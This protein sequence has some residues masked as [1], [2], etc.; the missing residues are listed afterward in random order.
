[1]RPRSA[2]FL[3]L[4]LLSLILVAAV[5]VARAQALDFRRTNFA[6]G[7]GPGSLV[8]ADLN[9]DGKLDLVSSDGGYP[10]TVSVLL[11]TGNGGFAARTAFAPARQPG[12][13]A[14]GDV[15]EDGHVDV[16][17]ATST[18]EDV[19]GPLVG[20][21]S[22]LYGDGAGR[23]S[24][25][26]AAFPTGIGACAVAVADLDKDGHLDIVT[27]NGAEGWD[28]GDAPGNS[29]SVLL[30]DGSGGFAAH[31]DFATGAYPKEVKVADLDK[32]GNL[33]LVT[34]N[35]G[36]WEAY[37]NTVSVLRG[38]GSGGFAAKTSFTTGALPTAVAV[39][40]LD[41]D[42]DLDLVSANEGDTTV[43]VLLGN[44][45]GGFASK[46]DFTMG[47]VA[48]S[49]RSVVVAD[50]DGDG[51]ADVATSNNRHD[52]DPFGLTVDRS[53]VLVRLGN[54]DGT[55]AGSN[56]PGGQTSF[57]TAMGPFE[58]VTADVNGDGRR[59]LVT[60]NWYADNVSVLLQQSA[61]APCAVTLTLSGL[62][63]GAIRRG[64]TVTAKGKATSACLGAKMVKLT[65][66][67]KRGASWAQAKVVTRS[68]SAT[69]TYGWK[70]KPTV[71]GAYRIRATVAKTTTNLA[72][73][74]PWRSFR[75]K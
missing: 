24:A 23:L 25:A 72:A 12:A 9:H 48:F 30:G 71:K 52:V 40:D 36:T 22:V 75:V 54:G 31:A 10:R 14:T 16:V 61:P 74:S 58:L 44:G 8:A 13:I 34:C 47:D 66:Q 68:L 20:V 57:A 63:S 69:A 17:M 21:V 29:V 1:M 42:G 67:R 33:D 32:D 41:K 43:S 27:A 73:A 56:Q 35:R 37:G 70:C 50:L 11:G 38:N 4:V 45:S 62:R 64:G 6:T 60:A 39:G 51:R 5:G 46:R 28:A 53:S 15:N 26:A 2:I 3:C 49:P 65:V 59:D 18:P 55:L 7:S 19:F